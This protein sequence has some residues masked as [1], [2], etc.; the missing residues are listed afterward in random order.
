MLTGQALFFSNCK[1]RKHTPALNE[2]RVYMCILRY[3]GLPAGRDQTI[4]KYADKRMFM[5]AL[6]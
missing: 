5:Y 2:G 4:A 1:H 6:S 3:R